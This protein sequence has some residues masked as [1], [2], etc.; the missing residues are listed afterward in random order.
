MDELYFYPNPLKKIYKP[1]LKLSVMPT[2]DMQIELAIY[3]VSGNLVYKQSGM[4]FA[5]LRNLELFDIP[6]DK[7]SSGIYFALI[8]GGGE[9]HRLRFGI[10]K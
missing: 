7:L 8:S 9:T 6:A 5:Y 1:Q 4:A 10:E 2:E 3:D